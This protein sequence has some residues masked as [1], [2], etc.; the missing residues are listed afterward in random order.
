MHTRFVQSIIYILFFFIVFFFLS[1]LFRGMFKRKRERERRDFVA[2][3]KKEKGE[4][5]RPKRNS[6]SVM[7]RAFLV[8]Y[9]PTFFYLPFLFFSLQ[10]V[11]MYGVRERDK[12]RLIVITR[13]IGDVAFSSRH[14]FFFFVF[15]FLQTP[16]G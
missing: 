4:R 3:K 16:L 14:F 6:G 8:A 10:R 7:T 1:L 11:L 5:E 2:Q 15:F 12:E 9:H 13:I